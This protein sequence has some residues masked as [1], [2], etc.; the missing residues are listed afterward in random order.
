MDLYIAIS[1][2][3]SDSVPVGPLRRFLTPMTIRSFNYALQYREPSPKTC[4]PTHQ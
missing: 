4:P 2:A 1:G 3:Y